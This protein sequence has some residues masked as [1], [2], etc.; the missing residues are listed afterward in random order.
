MKTKKLNILLISHEK[1]ISNKI[2]SVLKQIFQIKQL[3]FDENCSDSLQ[4]ESFNLILLIGLRS[5]M[6]A[7]AKLRALHLLPEVPPIILISDITDANFIVQSYRYGVID[8]VQVPVDMGELISVLHHQIKKSPTSPT[9]NQESGLT[10]LWQKIKPEL[11]FEFLN[12]ELGIISQNPMNKGNYAPD[13]VAFLHAQFFGKFRINFE[14]QNIEK[15]FGKRAKQLIS[16]ILHNHKKPISREKLI[17]IFWPYHAHH[18]AKNNLNV[19]IHNIRKV[20]ERILPNVPI[21]TLENDCYQFSPNIIIQTDCDQ[22]VQF[23]RNAKAIVSNLNQKN[24]TKEL[25]GII[26]LYKGDFLE[27]MY[28]PW[29]EKS[30]ENYREIYLYSLNQLS[31]LYFEIGQYLEAIKYNKLMLEK[32]NCMEEIHRKLMLCYHKL[33]RQN[34]VIR[35][36]QNCKK[37]LQQEL[38]ISPSQKTV[39]LLTQLRQA[40]ASS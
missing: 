28:E 33:D 18:A 35:Q 3:S 23:H 31:Q 29:M 39:A 13:N 40:N 17:E 36:F 14:N 30:R 24:A 6:D 27:S 20:F 26:A 21:L 9:L 11:N 38:E 1:Q 2:H 22:I 12:P 7:H 4:N 19:T 15:M 8:Y 16:F 32:D 5:P 37:V 34:K 25:Q 10:G